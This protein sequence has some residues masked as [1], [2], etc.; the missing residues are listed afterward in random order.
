[1]HSPH[2]NLF[3]QTKST[4]DKTIQLETNSTS[5]KFNKFRSR[6]RC[7]QFN[8]IPTSQTHHKILSF[9]YVSVKLVHSLMRELEHM[10]ASPIAH[11][12]RTINSI[13]VLPLLHFCLEYL[14]HFCFNI[15]FFILLFVCTNT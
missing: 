14:Y 12:T 4:P 6:R 1:M 3:I 11:K 10:F 13:F 15:R 8:C 5:L 7:R 9:P 2:E